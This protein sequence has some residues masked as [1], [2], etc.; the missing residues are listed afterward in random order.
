MPP[1]GSSIAIRAGLALAASIAPVSPRLDVALGSA[2]RVVAQAASTPAHKAGAAMARQAF[3]LMNA[4][5]GRLGIVGQSS[6]AGV[7]PRSANISSCRRAPRQLG[8]SPP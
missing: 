4:G 1:S 6:K 5:G 8:W 3:Q 2:P 7:A